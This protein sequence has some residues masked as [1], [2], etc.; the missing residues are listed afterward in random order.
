MSKHQCQL[1]IRKTHKL[2]FM[3]SFSVLLSACGN[4]E[5]EACIDRQSG[6]WDSTQD[7]PKKNSA[8]WTAVARCKQKYK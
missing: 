7:D 6:L 3:L 5:L 8:Y 1:I 4:P 2:F